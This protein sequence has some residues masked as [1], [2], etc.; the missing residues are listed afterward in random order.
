VDTS[1]SS[2]RILS[3]LNRTTDIH[4]K[5]TAIRADNGPEFTSNDFELWAKEQGITTQYIQPGRPMQNGCIERFNRLYEEPFWLLICS[6]I[7]TR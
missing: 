5:P 4:G 7:C 3:T 6:L 2:K 1:L